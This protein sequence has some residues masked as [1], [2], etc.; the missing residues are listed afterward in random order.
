VDRRPLYYGISI[1]PMTAMGQTR[2]RCPVCLKADTAGRFMR[3]RP[4][5]ENDRLVAT[6]PVDHADNALAQ[7][8]PC[9]SK[10]TTPTSS[11]GRFGQAHGEALLE[12]LGRNSLWL[13]S[14]LPRAL[15]YEAGKLLFASNAGMFDPVLTPVGLYV[16]QGRGCT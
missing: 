14:S 2:S 8:Q 9:C 11:R 7:A 15:E 6:S 4:K 13:S 16:E 1:R 3:T 12:A 5:S 10:D